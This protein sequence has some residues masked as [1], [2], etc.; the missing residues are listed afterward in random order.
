[1]NTDHHLLVAA[2]W[3]AAHDGLEG[4]GVDLATASCGRPGSWCDQLVERVRPA[5]EAHDDLAE[6][7]DLLAVAPARHRRGPAARGVRAHRAGWRTWSPTWPGRPVADRRG[8]GRRV[9]RTVDDRTVRGRRAARRPVG[10]RSGVAVV[11]VDGP[12]AAGRGRLGVVTE[13]LVVIG[14]DAAGMAAASQARRRR[15]VDDLEIV[16]FE[17]GHFTSYSACGIPYWIGGLVERAGRS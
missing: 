17:R 7:T 11:S 2:H 1:M 10:G 4:D 9:G 13:R 14:G 12:W 15:G 5:L 16:A 6:V 3:R 8:D